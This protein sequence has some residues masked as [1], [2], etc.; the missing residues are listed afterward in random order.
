[1]DL[2][3][4]KK[5][6]TL[7]GGGSKRNNYIGITGSDNLEIGADEDSEG[8]SSSIRFRVDGSERVRIT[9]GGQVIS[10]MI[11]TQTTYK[12]QIEATDNNVLRLVND[13]DDTNG[14]ELVLYKD[15]AS[16][17]DGDGIGGIYFQGND[18]GGNSVFYANIEGFA[19]DVSDGTEDGYIRFRN[20]IEWFYW[21]KSSH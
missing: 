21:R 13:S 18:D 10:V 9:S 11:F 16:P 15:S 5:L 12:T 14:V 17:A 6:I 2:L 4:Q 1:M 7:G 3:R 19:S 8:S 20:K